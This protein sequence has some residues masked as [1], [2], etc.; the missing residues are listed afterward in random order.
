MIGEF[1]GL[2]TAVAWS[3]TSIFFTIAAKRIGAIAVNLLRLLMAVFFL[4]LIHLFLFG[5]VL[6]VG[7]GSERWLW[8]GLS[9]LIGLV[10]GDTLLLLAFIAIGTRLSML[11]LSLV[12]IIS[13]VLAWVFLEEKLRLI[14]IVS[15]I[16]TVAGIAWVVTEKN[17]DKPVERKKFLLG[18]LAGVGGAL[19]QSFA[20]ITAKKGMA[21]DFPALS[22]T[23]IRIFIAMT[24]FWVFTFFRGKAGEIISLLK[25]KEVFRPILGGS[26]FGPV[27]GI[28]LSLI[29]IKYANVGIASTLMALPPILLIPLTHYFFNEKITV[30][31]VAGTFVAMVGVAVIF[32][33]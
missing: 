32:M 17:S 24:A 31:S 7:A 33:T 18:I 13:T 6:P 29:A 12:P 8:L 15:I 20:L 16:V 25:R 10:L 27:I 21:G 26:L 23:L 9:G 14:E 28:W 30:R 4:M 19:G 2:L 11:L 3:F 22:A 5:S 1:A